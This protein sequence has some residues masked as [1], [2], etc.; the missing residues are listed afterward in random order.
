MF[1]IIH[2]DLILYMTKLFQRAILYASERN[3]SH[4]ASSSKMEHV[5]APASL[6]VFL[7]GLCSARVAA[8]TTHKI[9]LMEVSCASAVVKRRH[10]LPC[11]YE[12][13]NYLV[14]HKQSTVRSSSHLGQ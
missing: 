6:P 11:V 13:D 12:V 14:L 8:L 9:A 2:G 7:V 1:V 5:L 3:R 4:F 10:N